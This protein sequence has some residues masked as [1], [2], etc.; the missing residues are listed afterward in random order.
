MLVR[1]HKRIRQPERHQIG[2]DAERRRAARTVLRQPVAEDFAGG[3]VLE[4]HDSRV[5]RHDVGAHTAYIRYVFYACREII[6][7]CLRATARTE[8]IVVIYLLVLS[9]QTY[10]KQVVCSSILCCAFLFGIVP[11]RYIARRRDVEDAHSCQTSRRA[12]VT[13]H[14][15]RMTRSQRQRSR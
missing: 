1:P 3:T 7:L 14:R 15:A 9:T 11:A 13:E 8:I 2:G 6:S 5:V 12:Q 4:A 10:Y